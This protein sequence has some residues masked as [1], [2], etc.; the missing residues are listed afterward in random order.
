MSIA[1][2]GSP[3]T[4]WKLHLN[5]T[6]CTLPPIRWWQGVGRWRGACSGSAKGHLLVQ[7]WAQ[8]CQHELNNVAAVRDE[9][10][11][12]HSMQ[13]VTACT[14][15]EMGQHMKQTA[16]DMD[17][18]AGTIQTRHRLYV[19]EAALEGESYSKVLHMLPVPQ[20]EQHLLVPSCKQLSASC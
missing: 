14:G 4:G 17:N 11:G 18:R 19:L 13:C 3:R 7:A 12:W 5:P 1:K 6:T 10:H 20:F 15:A 2:P 16:F 8:K 9:Q